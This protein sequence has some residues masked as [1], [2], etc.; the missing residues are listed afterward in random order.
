MTE[1]QRRTSVLEALTIACGGLDV[2]QD[3]LQ[4]IDGQTG[5]ANYIRG[6]YDV[7]RST[8]E[9]LGAFWY[10]PHP[11]AAEASRPD[12]FGAGLGDAGGED[13]AS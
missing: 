12:D 8:R 10:P 3:E 13:A 9:R 5:T 1:L 11:P 7:V 4:R 2:A 6:L